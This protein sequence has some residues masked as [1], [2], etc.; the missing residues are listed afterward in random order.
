[1]NFP[2][3]HPV[4]FLARPATL[5]LAAA[6]VLP[7]CEGEDDDGDDAPMCTTV[8]TSCTPAFQP[9]FDNVWAQVIQ[10]SCGTPGTSCH[11]EA[12]AAGAENGLVFSDIDG[13]YDALVNKGFVSPNDAACSAMVVRLESDNPN[14][15]MPPGNTPLD[16][17]LRCGVIQWIEGGAQR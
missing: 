13:A 16:P 14:T 7:A 2:R 1:M 11:G 10:P 15:R 5:A 12:G 4:L 8:D 6:T 17:G 3:R 9:T